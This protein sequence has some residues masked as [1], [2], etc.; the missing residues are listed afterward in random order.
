MSIKTVRLYGFLAKEFGREFHLDVNSPAEAVRALA[1]QI[2]G[3]ARALND[4]TPGFFVR[5][6]SDQVSAEGVRNRDLENP[7]STR[8]VIRIMPA[9]AGAGK[10]GQIIA[11]SLLIIAA[12]YAPWAST[13]LITSASGQTLMTVGSLMFSVGTNLLLGGLAQMLVKSPTPT[14]TERPD[15]R[16]SYS[17][18]GPVNTTQQ[19][20][21]V[22]ICYGEVICGSQVVSGGMYAEEL[23]T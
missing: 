23:T 2:R 4:Y 15:S 14:S 17:F 21:P 1:S 22:P 16:P 20:N 19:G 12:F 9:V 8:E 7:F 6:G 11:G 18:N 3:F 5:I 10:V 13:A